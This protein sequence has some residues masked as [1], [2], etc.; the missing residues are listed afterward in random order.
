MAEQTLP[1]EDPKFAFLRQSITL[2]EQYL[3]LMSNRYREQLRQ[4][5]RAS[6]DRLLA[7]LD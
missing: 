2:T 1:A 6:R 4:S 7:T 3:F 5:E